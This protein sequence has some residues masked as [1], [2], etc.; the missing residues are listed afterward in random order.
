MNTNNHREKS[1]LLLEKARAAYRN[2][3]IPGTY[4]LVLDSIREDPGNFKAYFTLKDVMST[5]AF[6]YPEIFDGERIKELFRLS[7]AIDPN[8]PILWNQLSRL[9]KI[10]NDY[11]MAEEA[12]FLSVIHGNTRSHWFNQIYSLFDLAYVYKN[13]GRMDIFTGVVFSIPWNV[14]IHRRIKRIAIPREIL[15]KRTTPVNFAIPPIRFIRELK[16]EKFHLLSLEG[17]HPA[18]EQFLR[19]L[20]ALDKKKIP[21]SF[22]H[23]P[24]L[25][26]MA[27]LSREQKH[28]TRLIPSDP[29]SCYAAIQIGDNFT[30][31]ICPAMEKEIKPILSSVSPPWKIVIEKYSFCECR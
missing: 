12:A 18:R 16:E 28:L 26:F 7:L 11:E 2:L 20:S 15:R 29:S 31:H 6:S 1:T 24:P 21:F 4:H 23:I 22:F 17:Q 5:I 3:D 14:N 13:M 25:V 27:G 8:V 9:H 10:L 30:L 19:L